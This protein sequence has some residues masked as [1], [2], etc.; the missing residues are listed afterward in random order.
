MFLAAFL[1]TTNARDT[2][3]EVALPPAE[4]PGLVDGYC[5]HSYCKIFGRRRVDVERTDGT[6]MPRLDLGKVYRPGG[7]REDEREAEAPIFERFSGPYGKLDMPK[8]STWTV[9]GMIPLEDT[10]GKMSPVCSELSPKWGSNVAH[11]TH[12]ATLED[13]QQHFNP[14]TTWENKVITLARDTMRIL[15]HAPEHVYPAGAP[16]MD[17]LVNKLAYHMEQKTRDRGVHGDWNAFGVMIHVLH[18]NEMMLMVKEHYLRVNPTEFTCNCMAKH[19]DHVRQELISIAEYMSDPTNTEIAKR[20]SNEWNVG[21]QTL[22]QVR[23][24]S[25]FMKRTPGFAKD[26]AI[27]LKCK[28]RHF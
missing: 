21:P 18:M 20:Y 27:Y 14:R 28:L 13:L 12:S 1:A 26:A 5:V 22:E 9:N 19:E 4:Y 2:V 17:R 11:A 6:E 25:E 3:T 24:D 23:R 7:P 16:F 15:D 8:L 10:F